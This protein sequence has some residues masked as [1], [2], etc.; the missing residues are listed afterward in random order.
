MRTNTALAVLAA[1]LH[2]THA[3]PANEKPQG[4]SELRLIKTSEQDPGQWVTDEEK[5]ER[6]TSK[7]IGFVD[8]TDITVSYFVFRYICDLLT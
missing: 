5:F 7:H 1:F 2:A 8:I 3:A 4:G 6:F